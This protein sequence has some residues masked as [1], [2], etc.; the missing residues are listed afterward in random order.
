M[1]YSELTNVSVE[2]PL[3]LS[4]EDS[5]PRKSQFVTPVAQHCHYF[6]FGVVTIIFSHII[7]KKNV[8]LPVQRQLLVVQNQC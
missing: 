3:Q 8:C 5:S 1:E 7:C 4:T 6:S 2:P